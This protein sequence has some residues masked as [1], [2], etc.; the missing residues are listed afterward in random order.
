MKGSAGFTFLELMVSV[1]ILAFGIVAIYEA[2]LTSLNVFASYSYYL[3]TRLWLNEEAWNVQDRV[4]HSDIVVTGENHGQVYRHD[5]KF[6]WM[7]TLEPLDV[8]EGLY[9]LEARLSWAEGPRTITLSRG[10][11]VIPARATV[12]E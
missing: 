12:H 6:D 7:M 9:A 10:G 1:A 5:K 2:L 4:N 11:Y 3:D 8:E